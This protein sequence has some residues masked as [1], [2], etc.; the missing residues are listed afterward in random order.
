[1]GRGLCLSWVAGGHTCQQG[2]LAVPPSAGSLES[3]MPSPQRGGSRF[4][5]SGWGLSAVSKSFLSLKTSVAASCGGTGL[6]SQHCKAAAWA[7]GRLNCVLGPVS[8]IN[9]QKI[10]IAGTY[11]N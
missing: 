6:Q 4:H 10:L 8:E 9:T 3:G 11:P 2:T 1:M 7:S 5:S